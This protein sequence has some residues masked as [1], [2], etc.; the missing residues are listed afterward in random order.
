MR[1]ES[2]LWYLQI[3]LKRKI[4]SRNTKDSTLTPFYIFA[5][6]FDGQPLDTQTSDRK[7]VTSRPILS[8]LRQLE[9]EV[10]KKNGMPKVRDTVLTS[11]SNRNFKT[12]CMYVFIEWWKCTE[13]RE[14]AKANIS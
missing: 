8:S 11:K 14:M 4:P 6:I 13:C 1:L 3:V 7:L 10:A 5:G 2:F 9:K 12:I